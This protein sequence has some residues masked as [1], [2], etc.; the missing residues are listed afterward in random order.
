[1]LLEA[2]FWLA[3]LPPLFAILVE[4]CNPIN[5]TSIRAS[6]ALDLTADFGGLS[7]DDF[8]ALLGVIEQSGAAIGEAS[9]LASTLIAS[10]ISGIAVLHEVSSPYWP[11]VVY[12]LIF[13]ILAIFPLWLMSG[14]TY[15]QISA[16]NAS[17][18][19]P[20]RT[21][22]IPLK[23][24]KVISLT[25]YAANVVLIIFAILVFS[26]NE[27]AR[28][29]RIGTGGAS[30]AIVDRQQQSIRDWGETQEL[31]LRWASLQD[32]ISGL[33]GWIALLQKLVAPPASETVLGPH[34]W[35]RIQVGLVRAGFDPGPIDGRSGPKTRAAIRRFQQQESDGA[36]AG[37]VLTPREIAQLWP[38]GA[39]P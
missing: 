30:V 13:I 1:M 12:V 34:G 27:T 36:G 4:A 8:D 11:I 16:R 9:G 25:I 5:G 32:Q 22:R 26:T 20:W 29:F 2:A 17:I 14:L 18:P 3:I 6:A 24:T 39:Q 28:D 19:T 37:G 38:G 33:A 31:L 23:R 35:Q 21:I 10:I 15:A 7:R